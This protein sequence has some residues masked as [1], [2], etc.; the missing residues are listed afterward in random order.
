MLTGNI[1]LLFVIETAYKGIRKF[2][3]QLHDMAS[4]W[5]TGHILS[6]CKLT[7]FYEYILKTTNSANVKN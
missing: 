7:H 4:R 5:L 2:P 1:R 6:H 3:L